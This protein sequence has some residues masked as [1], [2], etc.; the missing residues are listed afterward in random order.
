VE[1]SPI[2][3]VN[4]LTS[5][6]V[7]S[8]A[9]TNEKKKKKT[10]VLRQIEMKFEGFPRDS[11]QS[12]ETLTIFCV[13]N[14]NVLRVSRCINFPDYFQIIYCYEP[15]RLSINC[16]TGGGRRGIENS[17]HCFNLENDLNPGVT[18]LD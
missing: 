16:V 10:S 2:F 18:Y 6:L 12:H 8:V 3:S 17:K 14:R 7:D 15:S 11:R 13:W 5:L 1:T 4:W 9:S